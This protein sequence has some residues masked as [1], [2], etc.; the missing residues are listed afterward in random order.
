MAQNE[1][2]RRPISGSSIEAI[3]FFSG[4]SEVGVQSTP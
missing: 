1:L 4:F 3:C 2:R